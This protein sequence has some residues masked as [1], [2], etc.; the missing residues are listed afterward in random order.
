MKKLILLLF[1]FISALVQSQN[2]YT[3]AGDGNQ[4][5]SGDGLPAISN[6]C[7]LSFP[8][9][10]YIDKSGNL[11]IGDD[12]NNVV[13]II[14]PN[15]IISTFAGNHI[16]GAGYSGD[17]GPATD[18][19]LNEPVGVCGDTLGNIYVADAGNNVIR[20]ISSS[21]IISTYAGTGLHGFSGDSGPATNAELYLPLFISMDVHG[22]LFVVDKA[23]QRIRMINTSGIINTIAGNGKFGFTGDGGLAD[24]TELNSP[25]GV[26]TDSIGN[27][28]IADTYN[29]RIRKI[30]SSGII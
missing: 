17:N 10:V 30:N 5:F 14:N 28:Y 1:F 26:C 13:R 24:T 11:Y 16:L 23:N 18:A 3:V 19:Q 9:G 27:I 2:I 29:D 8:E 7:E 20:K 6:F 22:N 15:G 25:W 12:D 4:G 21:G